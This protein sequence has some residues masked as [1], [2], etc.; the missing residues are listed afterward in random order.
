MPFALKKRGLY[1]PGSSKPFKVSRSGIELFL[2]CPRCFYINHRFGIRRPAGPPFRLNS[3]VDQ[4][5]KKEFDF[6]RAVKSAHP[7]MT[8]YGIDAIPFQH[9]SL[10]D[11]RENFKGVQ[12]LH[13]AT[14]LLV[15][16]AVDDLWINPKGE[17]IVVDYKATAKNGEVNIDADWQKSY[18]RQIEV[19]QWL[20]RRQALDV[21]DTGYFVY[22]NGRDAH[23]FD[24]RIEFDVKLIPYKGNDN[25]VEVALVRLKACLNAEAVPLAS[26]SC[27]YCGYAEARASADLASATN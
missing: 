6:H 9:P 4:L 17:V 22:C 27:E 11:W 10:N 20:V 25:W 24:K 8:A 16:G 26:G 21:S 7:L 23:A 13:I 1:E 2:E 3:L 18:K 19:Y 5:L 14:N 12:T 15:A